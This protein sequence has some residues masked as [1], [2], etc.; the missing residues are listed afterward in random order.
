MTEPVASET[1]ET[2]PL[3][4]RKAKH[5]DLNFIL[6]SW[7]KSY[8]PSPANYRVPDAIYFARQADVIKKLLERSQ[9]LLA[10]SP[11]D[12]DQIFAYVV[13]EPSSS[14][15]ILHWI[16]TKYD[17]RH[18][19]IADRLVRELVGQQSEMVLFSHITRSEWL[20]RWWDKLGRSRLVYNPYL[21]E[22]A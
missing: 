10:V 13:G 1:R 11:E 16:F 2:P 18:F 20:D 8:K 4:I 9:I 15:P 17:F 19:G 6:N 5:G 12:D 21:K 22:K 14:P 7:L 3:V